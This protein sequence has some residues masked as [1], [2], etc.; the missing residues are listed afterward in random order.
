M[1]LILCPECNREISDTLSSC[2][3]C[4]YVINSNTTPNFRWSDLSP[5]KGFVVRGL[6]CILLGIAIFVGVL[7]SAVFYRFGLLDILFIVAS[8][9]ISGYGLKRLGG[10][11]RGSCPYCGVAVTVPA[12]LALFKCKNCK[13][14]STNRGHYLEGID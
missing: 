6:F 8:F 1:A 11:Q 9:L 14:K 5:K 13:K 4:G 7:V 3:Y 2:H 10:V 12:R